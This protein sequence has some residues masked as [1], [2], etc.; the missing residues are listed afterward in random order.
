[1]AS[2]PSHSSLTEQNNRRQHQKCYDRRVAHN[3]YRPHFPISPSPV[4]TEQIQGREWEEL[5]AQRH[6]GS[7]ARYGG[8]GLG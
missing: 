1:M 4:H 6:F 3:R 2:Q 5:V 7:L 8:R